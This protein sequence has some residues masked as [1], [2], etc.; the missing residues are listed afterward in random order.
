MNQL[1]IV[2]PDNYNNFRSRRNWEDKMRTGATCQT[3]TGFRVTVNLPFDEQ[4][5]VIRIL[6]AR[7][8]D[9]MYLAERVNE[10]CFLPIPQRRPASLGVKLR[11]NC[12][13]LKEDSFQVYLNSRMDGMPFPMDGMHFQGLKRKT[14]RSIYVEATI[15]SINLST[16]SFYKMLFINYELMKLIDKALDR[17]RF[18]PLIVN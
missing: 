5:V 11:K 15:L 13:G 8:K 9:K 17:Y 7:T 14:Q 16:L 12:R 4:E 2:S 3:S 1:D 18:S 10:L 6:P